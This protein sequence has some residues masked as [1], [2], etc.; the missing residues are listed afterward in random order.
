ME[1]WR[2]GMG[3]LK[4]NYL[5]LLKSEDNSSPDINALYLPS[6]HHDI[7]Y[8][9]LYTRFGGALMAK[10]FFPESLLGAVYTTALF[11]GLI[12]VSQWIR[13][14]GFFYVLE[15]LFRDR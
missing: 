5:L 1:K 13:D 15:G 6:I 10:M 7:A 3:G 4:L 11:I 14:G 12:A 8:L 2:K 9:S